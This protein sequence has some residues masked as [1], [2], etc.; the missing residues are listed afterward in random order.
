MAITFEPLMLDAC[1]WHWQKALMILNNFNSRHFSFICTKR[2]GHGHFYICNNP[3]M[4]AIF[5]M[6]IT[7]EPLMLDAC[8]WYWQKALMI[9]NNFCSRHF[10]PICSKNS[11]S[12]HFTF[13]T[14]ASGGHF[15]KWPPCPP[16][17]QSEMGQY[18]N[19]FIIYQSTCVPNFVLL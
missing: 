19:L 7:F 8:N 12:D 9:L 4:A 13:I 14:C 2:Y 1:N 3:P 10:S 17:V 5:K 16:K 18:P 11:A 6:A 15:E